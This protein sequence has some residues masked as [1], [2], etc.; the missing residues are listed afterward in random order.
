MTHPLSTKNQ[1]LVAGALALFMA[2]TRS[3]QVPG[4]DLLH[5]GSWAVFFA[6]GV[7]LNAALALPALL[8][9]AFVLDA[10]AVG[11]SGVS[12]YC[13]TPAYAMLLPAYASLWGA[14]RWYA[15]QHRFAWS[16][17]AP[18]VASV[19][20]GALLCEAFSSGGFYWLS[21]QFANPSLAEFAAREVTY[22]PAYLATMAF[23]VAATGVAHVALVTLSGRDTIAGDPVS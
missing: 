4:G 22:F 23:W 15:S 5:G 12:A 18:L 21:G 6:A 7:Y 3:P 19:L 16:T 1:L 14:G 11:W 9:L 2:V 20:V 13:F 17:V 10:V 8:V